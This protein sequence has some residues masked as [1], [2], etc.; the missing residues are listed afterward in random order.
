MRSLSLRGDGGFVA[1]NHLRHIASRSGEGGSQFEIRHVENALFREHIGLR[2]VDLFVGQDLIERLLFLF[3][4]VVF[5]LA[6]ESKGARIMVQAFLKQGYSFVQR[7]L[8]HLVSTGETREG[9]RPKRILARFV[10]RIGPAMTH[11]M[12]DS[13]RGYDSFLAPA[14]ADL[15]IPKKNGCYAGSKSPD[16]TPGRGRPS[17][18]ACEKL[19]WRT[20]KSAAVATSGFNHSITAA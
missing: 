8:Q 15:R 20:L 3:R 1:L 2:R 12:R 11:V 17:R 14:F 13:A 5:S 18:Y 9:Q 16:K 6:R 10:R 4:F 7:L 19:V